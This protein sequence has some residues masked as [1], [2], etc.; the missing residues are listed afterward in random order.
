MKIA[1]I[2]CLER[3]MK[4]IEGDLETLIKASSVE[5]EKALKF[6]EK[7]LVSLRTGKASASLVENIVVEAHGQMMKVRELAS[8]S[9]PEARMIVIHPWDKSILQNVAKGIMVSDLGINPVVD[10]EVVRLQLP[11]M[12]GE[13]REEM[14]KQLSKKLEDSKI[15]MRAVRKD[16]LQLIKTSE[17]NKD[18][19]EDFAKRIEDKLQKNTDAW[20]EKAVL[21]AKKKEV[22]LRSV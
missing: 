12:S 1:C 22:E 16:F 20:I 6:F 17:K 13:R 2:F 4:I 21:I 19:S 7:D 9:T 18:I 8:I 14:V 5:M 15:Q 11:M 10:G 3:F